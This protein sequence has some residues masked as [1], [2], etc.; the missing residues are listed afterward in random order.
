MHVVWVSAWL[1]AL[2]APTDVYDVVVYGGTSA[3]VSAA[4]Q[5]AR[6]GKSVALVS[7]D[8]HLGGLSADGL[9]WTDSGRKEAVG[10]LAREFYRRIKAH[11]DRPEAWVQQKP[12][13][14]PLYRRDDDAIWAFEPHVAERVFEDLVAENKIPVFREARLDRAGGVSKDG[15]AIASLRT[16]DGKTFRGRVFIDATYEGDLM[17]AAGVSYAVGREPNAK[18]GETLNG[19]AT[20]H[21]VSHQ[22]ETPVDPYV[23]PGDPASGLLPGVHA[24][25]PGKE[26]EGDRRVQAYCF[27]MCLTDAPD[28][29]VPFPKPE[30]YDPGRY[31][32]LGRYLRSG[33]D[34]VFRKF[35]P[36]PNRKTDTNNHGAFSTDHIGASDDYPEAT[37]ERRRAIVLDHERYQKGLMYY[38]ANDPGVPEKTRKEAAR[39]G[40]A[41]D[42]FTDNGHWP[43]QIYVREARRMVSDFVMTERHL[44]GN[45]PT[46]EPVGMGSYNMDSHN[47]QRYVD[48]NGH[49]RN[50]G[51]FQVDPGGPYPV[52]YR[53]LV[54]RAGECTNLL[55]PV[56][57]ASSHVAYGS[58]RM[59]PVFLA[60]GQSAATAAALAVDAGVPV[61]KV[62]YAALRKRLLADGQV[63][64][65]PRTAGRR[66]LAAKAL[67]GVVVD[68]ADAETEGAWTPSAAL[69]PYVGSGYRHDGDAGKGKKSAT[70]RAK[71]APGRYEVRVAFTAS[72][73]RSAAVPVVV[74]HP[75]GPTR[76]VVDQS[77]PPGPGA[78]FAAVGT[79][80]FDGPAAVE[81]RNEGTTG[82]VIVDAVQFLKDPVNPDPFE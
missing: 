49:A 9:G 34:G 32:L 40:L 69:G 66:G 67:A 76:V 41:R 55:V 79:F 68:D 22:F 24:G 12:D 54:P 28:N 43:H 6:M 30:G 51:D 38:L 11:Y 81:V 21:A 70:F 62:G 17:A 75:R 3:G 61:Q 73:N 39:W 77:R 80:W 44:R 16:L 20:R 82:H 33:W 13:D 14:Y 15:T 65:L 8:V 37:D 26:G 5:A 56:C 50:E 2:A 29:R 35:D 64:E 58:I 72:G 18:Y 10:G 45:E 31:E 57:L 36:V 23:I 7:P 59:E 47:V 25:P 48:A 53:A 46:P 4:V 19:V 60:L 78:P 1:A 52:S 42:E 27:R 74:H 63:L 71:L